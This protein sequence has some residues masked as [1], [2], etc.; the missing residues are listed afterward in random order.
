MRRVWSLR[1]QVA[2]LAVAWALAWVLSRYWPA[3]VVGLGL[4]GVASWGP[5]IVYLWGV[6]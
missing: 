3:L 6:S 5:R 4:W 1:F 2:G